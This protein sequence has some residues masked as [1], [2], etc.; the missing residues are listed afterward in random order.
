MDQV[1][2]KEEEVEVNL[3]RQSKRGNVVTNLHSGH[4]ASNE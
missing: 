4:G 1:K 3:C 2:S